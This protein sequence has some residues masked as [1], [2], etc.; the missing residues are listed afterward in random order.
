MTADN[1]DLA[2]PMA[3]I[4]TAFARKPD[5]RSQLDRE[6]TNARKYVF[7]RYA[8]ALTFSEQV[9]LTLAAAGTHVVDTEDKNCF[10]IYPRVGILSD[11]P[12]SGKSTIL[13]LLCHLSYRGEKLYTRSTTAPGMLRALQ[14]DRRVLCLDQL[15]Y[16][17]SHSGRSFLDRID[18]IESGY[19]RQ[20]CSR[21]A[22]GRHET[23]AP[24]FFA[25]LQAM[26]RGN[27]NLE[28]MRS[29]TIQIHTDP[30][31]DG[32]LA[33]EDLYSDLSDA[34]A[35]KMFGERLHIAITNA[36]E[37]ILT[38]ELRPVAGLK[39]RM[40]EKW[41]PL[42]QVAAAAGGQW[43]E[44]VDAAAREVSLGTETE[45]TAGGLGLFE[46]DAIASIREFL[47]ESATDNLG[48]PELLRRIGERTPAWYTPRQGADYL[49]G[50]ME[51]YGM[52]EA[53]SVHIASLDQARPGWKH[54]DLEAVFS[55]N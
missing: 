33:E 5:R 38:S 41:G 8:P 18:I 14:E 9:T 24:V 3:Q 44:W 6:L 42:R 54:S 53:T 23:F 25:C 35:I 34:R 19:E 43:P 29:R 17:L 39:L 47:E 12:G 22:S 15:E 16:I 36:R 1:L 10:G 4:E 30:L 40:S 51:N 7:A 48:R 55:E 26:F 45:T 27:P 32:M 37:A 52:P 13:T 20:G 50:I 46:E 2:E 11:E 49:N 21:N 31:P 28:A